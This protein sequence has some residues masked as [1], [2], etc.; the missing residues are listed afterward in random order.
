[1]FVEQEVQPDVSCVAI[2]Y[3]HQEDDHFL[4]WLQED[5]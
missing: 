5:C 2:Q 3:S 4:L 1:M